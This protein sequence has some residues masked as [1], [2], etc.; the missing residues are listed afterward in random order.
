LAVCLGVLGNAHEAED[1]AQDALMRGFDR[2]STLRDDDRFAG[3][4]AQVARTTALDRLRSERRRRTVES[5]RPLRP[6]VESAG[7]RLEVAD[8]IQRLPMELRTVLVMFHIEERDAKQVAEIL[9]MSHSTV[10]ARLRVAR[11]TLHRILGGEV[12]SHG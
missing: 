9:G 5:G 8:A 11:L 12:D 3:W 1:A 4:I 6:S 7:T 2:I 10:C